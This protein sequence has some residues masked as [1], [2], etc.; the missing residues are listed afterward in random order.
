VA[1]AALAGIKVMSVTDHDTVAGLREAR[2]AAVAYGI[3]LVNGI[4]VTSVHEQRDVHILGYFIHPEEDT[5]N[6]FLQE[7]R[8][9]RTT[10]AREIG[11][12]LSSVGLTVDI[13]GVIA[14]AQQTPGA[15]IGRPAIA[16][17]LVAAGHVASIDEAF[18]R[19]LGSGRPAF[20]PR[21]GESPIGVI[22]WIHRAHGLASMAHPGVTKKPDLMRALV[23]AGLDAIE[24][25]HSDHAPETVR[26]L[27]EFAAAHH[28]LLTGGSDFHGDDSR[29]RVLGGTLLPPSDFERL[30]EATR[31][32]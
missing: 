29:R 7:Q 4:E 22:E 25:Y 18:E 20:V 26:D 13:E 6:A 21:V 30:R 10:R 31:I 1:R 11:A 27:K 3:D 14:R 32:R 24:V 12:R 5:F 15:A 28:L 8:E 9:R 19:Y 17:A 16:R 2:A 23:D